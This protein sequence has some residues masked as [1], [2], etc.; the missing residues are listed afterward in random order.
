MTSILYDEFRHSLERMG[1]LGPYDPEHA[2][3]AR[4]MAVIWRSWSEQFPHNTAAKFVLDGIDLSDAIIRD[5]G[6]QMLQHQ[7]LAFPSA[8][9]YLQWDQDM[10]NLL[11]GKR[12][13][14]ST[15]M[16]VVVEEQTDDVLRVHML[17]G[18]IGPA[19]VGRG[20]DLPI[21]INLYGQ[22]A[23]DLINMPWP[24]DTTAL[25]YQK[26]LDLQS[27]THIEELLCFLSTLAMTSVEKE[28]RGPSPRI[29]A[30]RIKRGQDP[31]PDYVLL[32]FS[33]SVADSMRSAVDRASPRPHFR[34]GHVRVIYKGSDRQRIVAVAPSWVNASPGQGRVPIYRV[35]Q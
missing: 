6:V 29:Q 28:R 20:F 7:V 9:F 30:K 11:N 10:T 8:A 27:K 33:P 15:A 16:F 14:Q 17:C 13:T 21:R 34:R 26:Q 1:E 5:F 4:E 32:R 19:D 31:L 23:T 18:M 22:K 3:E 12:F 24:D 2:T 35:T 25:E